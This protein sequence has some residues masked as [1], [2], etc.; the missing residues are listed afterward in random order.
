[1]MNKN[2]S[3]LK[4]LGRVRSGHPVDW[5]L[6][7]QRLQKAGVDRKLIEAAVATTAYSDR[8]YKVTIQEEALFKE[9]E[10][11]VQPIDRSSRSSASIG[12]NTHLVPVGG[13][14]LA[15][16]YADEEEPINRIFREGHPVPLPKRQH[17]L[18]IENE[19]CFLN[20][21][22][23]YLF[24][25][26]HCGVTYSI[27]DVEFIYGSGNSISNRRI[28][29]YLEMF[30]G[31]VMCLL[32]VDTGGLQIYSNLLSAG[33]SEDKI[34]YLIP[35]DI[36]DRL[37][38]SKRKASEEELQALSSL[39]GRCSLIDKLITA[40]RHFKSTVEQESYRAK[41]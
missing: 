33:L 31:K 20:K 39:Y 4:I 17:A 11:L 41:R 29:P 19:E 12:G 6:T 3:L 38:K 8:E 13:A 32:D 36:N 16:W 40:I 28:T 37:Q 22:D 25:K 23:T 24:V 34:N 14:M 7:A 18:I 26:E 1:M 15:V 27:D 5:G 30:S 35:S 21:E 2:E 10:A 9:I